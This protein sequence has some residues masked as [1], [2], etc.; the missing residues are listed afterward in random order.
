MKLS[1]AR[2]IEFDAVSDLIQI[3][4]S[5]LSNRQRKEEN[6]KSNVQRKYMVFFNQLINL[7]R[8]C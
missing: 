3:K 5:T 6:E 2:N 1:D 4:K 8:N 7:R